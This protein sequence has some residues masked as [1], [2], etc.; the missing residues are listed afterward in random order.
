MCVDVVNDASYDNACDHVFIPEQRDTT[1]YPSGWKVKH[2]RILMLSSL[3]YIIH[4]FTRPFPNGSR[5][6]LFLLNLIS[7]FVRTK[8]VVSL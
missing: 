5:H 8:Q 7:K 2:N 3:S 6:Q 4:I 1:Y